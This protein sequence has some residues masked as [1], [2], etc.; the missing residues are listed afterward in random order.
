[1]RSALALF[2]A[3]TSV[4]TAPFFEGSAAAQA[5]A[6]ARGRLGRSVAVRRRRGGLILS[7]R[8]A[9][10]GP[11]LALAAHLD[12]PAFHL[13]RATA[14]GAAGR[15]M[16]GLPA[17]LLKGAAVEAFEAG[18]RSNVPAAQG[19]VSGPE[20]GGF[21]PIR[22]TVPPARGAKPAFAVLALTP[23]SIQNGWLLSRSID[24]LLGCAISLEVLRQA[25]AG[26]WKTNLTVLLHRAEEVG[27]IG[28]LDL[29]AQGAV[30]PE[31][32][33]I[34]VETSRE[35]PGARPG[36][37]PVV[38][39]GDKACL[40]DG[41]L[42][43]LLDLAAK[44]TARRGLRCQRLRLM[45][46]TCEAAAYQ[47]F[48][49]EAGGVAV[50]LVNYH[51]GWGASAVAPEK[52]RLS[53]AAGAIALLGEAARLFPQQSALRGGLRRRLAQRQA[54]TTSAFAKM[55]RW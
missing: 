52:V 53:D 21:F 1:M 40:F 12:H 46:G 39:L 47:A 31:D 15:L 49:Y 23:F 44:N 19:L 3:L 35:L 8:G 9:G 29:I 38:R 11:A 25:A 34:S 48:G 20:A 32:S 18:A 27:F 41:N 7:Y 42:T 14:Q 36:R 30:S 55:G 45:G 22:W 6:W 17:H 50:P 4:P 24:D 28:A 26:R 33:V 54:K 51:N 13:S 43:A 10:P 5:L 16:G 37:G 2:A